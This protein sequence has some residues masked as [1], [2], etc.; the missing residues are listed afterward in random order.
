MV[1]FFFGA[2]FIAEADFDAEVG[3]GVNFVV[4]CD[5]D[6]EVDVGFVVTSAEATCVSTRPLDATKDNNVADINFFIG[7]YLLIDLTICI[8]SQY[9]LTHNVVYAS[10]LFTVRVK[11]KHIIQCSESKICY[12]LLTIETNR[13]KSPV[14]ITPQSVNNISPD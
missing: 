12:F 3:V 14:M 10:S 1:D 6:A 13:L 2:G 9:N 5:A 7:F 11:I 4:G 8:I